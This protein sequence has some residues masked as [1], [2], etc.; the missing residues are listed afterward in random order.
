M[1]YLIFIIM[2]VI[3]KNFYFF[4]LIIFYLANTLGS[5]AQKPQ[6]IARLDAYTLGIHY[7]ET[8]RAQLYS[9]LDS[10]EIVLAVDKSLMFIKNN[11]VVKKVINPSHIFAF[12]MNKNGNGVIV[13]WRGEGI[14]K[15]KNFQI[16]SKPIYNT[17][18][19]PS[20]SRVIWKVDMINDTIARFVLLN[21][22]AL[23]YIHIDSLESNKYTVEDDYVSQFIAEKALTNYVGKY[24]DKYYFFMYD[25]KEKSHFLLVKGDLKKRDPKDEKVFRLGDLGRSAPETVSIRYDEKNN[26]FYDMLF[27]DNKMVLYKFDL[28]NYQ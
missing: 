24:K 16:Q 25:I 20:E 8:D 23:Y 4:F 3:R 10:N 6:I 17:I 7:S 14:F 27:K 2:S 11:V 26:I 15:I 28:N 21:T 1:F 12:D 9:L 18:E 13:S 5:W 19:N 22:K